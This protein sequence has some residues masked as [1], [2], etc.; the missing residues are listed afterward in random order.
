MLQAEWSCVL[1]QRRLP[2][3]LAL[4]KGPY[5]P[6]G[7]LGALERGEMAGRFDDGALS[8][9]DALPQAP[10][11]L[12]EVRV[13][14]L[15]HGHQSM[16][17][18]PSSASDSPCSSKRAPASRPPAHAARARRALRARSRPSSTRSDTSPGRRAASSRHTSP[19]N[20]APTGAACSPP[21]AFSRSSGWEDSPAGGKRSVPET[22]HP[23]GGGAGQVEALPHPGVADARVDE[24]DRA[25]AATWTHWRPPR[26]RARP[27]RPPAAPRCGRPA[28]CASCP[29]SAFRA[30]CACG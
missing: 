7:R 5:Q 4:E 29:P 10:G 21:S 14:E 28:S 13:V 3:S 20:E 16:S 1:E 24:N 17:P 2:Q 8:A 19:P 11:D 27:G 23:A 22:A 9:L 12:V 26:A 30:A 18:D 25:P 15:T 6:Y